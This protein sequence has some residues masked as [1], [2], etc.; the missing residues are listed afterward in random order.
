MSA[1][2]TRAVFVV[3]E[4]VAHVTTAVSSP[5]RGPLLRVADLHR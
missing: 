5:M 1:E 2:L 4:R 3:K